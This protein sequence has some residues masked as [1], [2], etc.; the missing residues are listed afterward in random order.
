M[1]NSTNLKP[2][3]G[4]ESSHDHAS[5]LL[6]F[7]AERGTSLSP[8]LILTHDYPDP[9]ALAAAFGLQHLLH[10]GFGI[11]SRLGYRGEIGRM[12]NRAM[13]R[14]LRIPI[15]KLPGSGVSPVSP[16]WTPSPVSTTIPSRPTSTPLS[17]STS[18]PPTSRPTRTSSSWTRNAAP[19]A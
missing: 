15:R 18:M 4:A 6:R 3:T 16:S 12:E 13:V 10:A 8:L 1:T 9:D 2:E 5:R 17:L 14:L 7:L 11:E 19:P